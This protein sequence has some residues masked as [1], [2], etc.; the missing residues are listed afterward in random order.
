MQIDINTKMITLIGKPLA[1]SFSARMQNKAYEAA[2][3]NMVFFYTEPEKEQLGDI[4]KGLR[5][6]NIAGF[7]VTK[8]YKVDVIP[9][10]DE[11]DPLCAK[12]GATNTVVKTA[13]GKL[14]GYNTDGIGFY[15]GLIEETNIKVDQCVFFCFGGGGAGRAMCSILAHKGA[16]KIY[17]TDIFETSSRA[18]V[19]DINAKFAPV[20][21]WVPYG[22]FSKV[23]ACDVVLN[24][25]GIGMGHSLGETPL[26]SKFV[27]RSQIYF[28]ACYNPNKTQFLLNAEEKGCKIVNGLSMLLYQGAVQLELWAGVKPPIKVMRQELLNIIA[29]EGEPMPVQKKQLA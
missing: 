13:T 1:Q 24:A 12:M 23:A 29:E 4:I 8:P 6:M 10:L 26:P 27:K 20:A 11:L 15:T 25:S 7:S 28:D 19:E 16:K 17:I 22:D 9:Y 18:L 5:Y 3:L 14:I 21:E 2:G